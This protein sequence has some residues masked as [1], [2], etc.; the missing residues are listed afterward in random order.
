MSEIVP[1]FPLPNVVLL[2]RAVLPLHIFEERYRDMTADALASDRRI[3]MALL[4]PGWTENYH[5][6]PAIE[7]VVCVGEILRHEQLEDGRY[8][9]LLMGRL[10]AQVLREERAGLYRV[11]EVEPLDGPDRL[12]IDLLAHRQ[13]LTQLLTGE[14]PLA[15]QPLSPKFAELLRSVIPTSEA[16][17]VI[18]YHMVDDLR[19]KQLL[20]EEADP[21]VRL[22]RV[23]GL[24]EAAARTLKGTNPPAAFEGRYGLN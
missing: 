16:A 24:L 1:V 10:R 3:A 14:S 17:D 19:E 8:N 9:L 6:I 12:E 20:L 5:G 4:R 11:A 18:A 15:R 21:I 2:P 13:K 7:P 22:D 23:I